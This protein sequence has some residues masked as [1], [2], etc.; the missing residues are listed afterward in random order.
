MLDTGQKFYNLPLRL[1]NDLEVK[2][3]NVK[4]MLK[5]LV[6]VYKKT[7]SL[8]PLDGSSSYLILDTGRGPIVQN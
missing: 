7:A 1:T 2:V 3:T 8:E 5:F 6:E 4:F